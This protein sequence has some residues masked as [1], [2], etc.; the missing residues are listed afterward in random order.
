[1]S[2]ITDTKVPGEARPYGLDKSKI[3]EFCFTWHFCVGDERHGVRHRIVATSMETALPSPRSTDDLVRGHH[4]ALSANHPARLTRDPRR[5]LADRL[6][7]LESTDHVGQ[8]A[9]LVTQSIGRLSR[10]CAGCGIC[11]GDI[12]DAHQTLVE[13]PKAFGLFT[14][15]C[16]N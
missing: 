12:T 7:N 5:V 3:A 2:L 4:S 1:M 11:L 8:I 14:G 15:G 10:L 16:G 13:N 6:V 9:N